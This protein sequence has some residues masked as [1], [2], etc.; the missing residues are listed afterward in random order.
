MTTARPALLE[1]RDPLD[2]IA[3]AVEGAVTGDA[4]VVLVEGEGGI[5]KTSL[6]AEAEWLAMQ[7]GCVALTAR[8][9]M[10]EH[11]HGYAIVRQLFEA[12]V[13]QASRERQAS[14]LSG[15]AALVGAVLGIESPVAG[16][17]Q[18]IMHGLYWLT[19]GLADERPLV[20]LVDDAQWADPASLEWL[21]YL[22]QRIE[23]LRI[24]LV[25][26]LR[27]GEPDGPYGLLDVLAA[28]PSA[29]TVRLPALSAAATA[30]L[31]SQAFGEPPD[32]ALVSAC[33]EQTGGNPW[34]VGTL[35]RE[36]LAEGHRPT[37]D[38]VP[39]LYQL[40]PDAVTRVTRLRLERQS[41]DAVALI[42][43]LAILGSSARLHDAAQLAGLTTEAAA[44]AVDELVA[45]RLLDM[46]PDPEF[47]H[48]LV[49]DVVYNDLPPGRRAADH[50][51]AALVLDA[52]GLPTERLA[53]HL[54][55][56]TPAGDPWM[57]QRL[58]AAAAGERSRGA[59]SAAAALLA[60]A[61]DE[62]PAAAERTALLCELG[63]VRMLAGDL[64]AATALR[65]ALAAPADPGELAR[66]A[67][68]L[69]RQLVFAGDSRGAVE[70]LEPA[71]EVAS[72]LDARMTLEAALLTAA[73]ADRTL[74]GIALERTAS[75][76][77]AAR[78]STRAG[79]LVDGL[80]AYDAAIRG[81]SATETIALARAALGSGRVFDEPIEDI[82]FDVVPMSMLAISDALEEAS[83]AYARITDRLRDGGHVIAFGTVSA[84]QSWTSYLRGELATAELQARDA[85][86]VIAESPALV[87][88]AGFAR[89]HLAA[90]LVARGQPEEAG[91]LVGDPERL[92]AS[93][94]TWDRN[95]L[96]VAGLLASSQGRFEEASR[97]LLR[98]GELHEEHGIVNPAFSAWRSAAALALARVG[99]QAHAAELAAEELALARR[100][101]AARPIGVALRAA[102]VVAG[103][104]AG[105]S[106]LEE[107]VSTLHGSPAVLERAESLV[108]LGAAL[109]RAGQRVGARPALSEGLEIA[110]R[111]G[112][113]P[114][115]ERAREELV[116]AG[117]RPRA[118]VRRGPDALTPSERRVATMASEGLS[119]PEIAQRLFVTRATVE[120]HLHAAYRKLGIGS[121]EEIAAVLGESQ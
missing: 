80:L 60:R 109:R 88:P 32:P 68:L 101:G 29:E 59:A 79:R 4:H 73:L 103:D 71:I 11:A 85:L 83:A 93:S 50:K 102:G 41:D 24:A 12:Q 20:L 121:R 8:G 120:S 51:R 10:L 108:A 99:E 16:D 17:A 36:L 44:R 76:R 72:D 107:S 113:V 14:L 15:P 34:L 9:G 62:P 104:A 111:C 2:R 58:R 39:R 89:G 23:G 110:L 97:W 67:L 38:A 53:A 26:A 25:V 27:L 3:G 98:C 94:L 96:Y 30:T 63:A 37:A 43:A 21:V 87:A 48:P 77:A 54:L 49:R 7:R 91:Q 47:V 61:L 66:A 118:V 75:L 116:A 19:A 81:E 78:P 28:Q 100:F 45:A 95:N 33:Y 5:G 86:S 52:Q 92:A 114:L 57:V 18:G 55:A 13:A 112:A 84:L 74:D 70:V 117:S 69:G 35:S 6:L 119:N 40:V 65:E 106:Q 31:M 105:L 82:E 64:S 90:T 56:S 115:A 22:A 46:D 42:Q 1:R